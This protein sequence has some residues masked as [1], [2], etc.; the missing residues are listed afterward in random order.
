VQHAAR[1]TQHAARRTQHAA[2]RAVTM[3]TNHRGKHLVAP[4]AQQSQSHSLQPQANVSL[5]KRSRPRLSCWSQFTRFRC[6]TRNGLRQLHF[7][8]AIGPAIV[9]GSLGRTIDHTWSALG[10]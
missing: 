2:R 4:T 9:L 10:P 7:G 5:A 1:S 8:S 6:A 3:Q